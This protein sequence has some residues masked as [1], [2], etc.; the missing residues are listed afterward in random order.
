MRVGIFSESYVPVRNGVS[1]S[2]TTLTDELERMGHQVYIFAPA[3]PGF[4]DDKNNVIRFPSFRT[5]FEP[6][7]PIPLPYFPG[8]YNKIKELEIDIIHTQTPWMLGWLGLRIAKKLNIPIVSTNHTHYPQYAHYFPLAPENVTKS[9]IINMMKKYYNQCNG[10]IVPSK[11]V[12]NTLREY[13][14]SKSIHIIPT[15]ISL[16]TYKDSNAG[17]ETRKEYG[18]PADAKV[19]IYAGR[20]A[21]EKN[22]S[23][24]FESFET[25]ASKYDNLWLML[26]GGGPS[27]QDF[28]VTAAK[29]L[30]AARIILTG[31]VPREQIARYYS[32]GDIFVFPSVTETQGLVLCEA[33]QA[34][35]PCVAVNAG[36]SPEMITDNEDGFLTKNKAEDF[37]RKITLLLDDSLLFSKFSSKAVENS[38]RFT[39]SGMAASMLQAY[40]S[41]RRSAG[42]QAG[43]TV[44]PHV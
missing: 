13:G 11:Q 17:L 24:L 12:K 10:V 5:R 6:E 32:A 43:L 39:S 42:K 37:T 3:Y 44:K 29:S 15:G 36:G 2:V 26:V 20:I 31:S 22:L 9:F 27:E 1:V 33:L 38:M 19:L 35:L 41:I 18:I 4:N 34:G 8:I 40:E 7:Y 28:R 30:Y 25:L 16:N 21:K 14:I 23:L